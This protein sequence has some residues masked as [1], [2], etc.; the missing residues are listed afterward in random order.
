[1]AAEDDVQE[2]NLIAACR[3]SGRKQIDLWEKIV[4]K[5]QLSLNRDGFDAALVNTALKASEKLVAYGF[6][7][8]AQRVELSGA[9][10]GAIK[11]EVAVDWTKISTDALQELL[12]ARAKK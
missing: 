5:A 4:E 7:L 10:G 12:A 11:S 9:N 8:P 1:L 3:I 6:G 2:F